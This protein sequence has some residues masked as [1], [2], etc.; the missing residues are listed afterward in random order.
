MKFSTTT[1]PRS[2]ASS[3]LP[4]LSSRDNVKFCGC[5]R[6]SAPVHDLPDQQ[7]EQPGD[8]GDGRELSCQLEPRR[9]QAGTMI[10]GVPTA[11]WLKSHSAEGMN[12]RMQPCEAE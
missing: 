4:G 12:M 7:R 11:T 8:E 5:G 3:S 6:R 10:T 1:L 9:H 2:D